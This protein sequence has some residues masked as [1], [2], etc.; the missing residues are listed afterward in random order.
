MWV[1]SLISLFTD[2]ASEMLYPV[3]PL[4][5]KQIGYTAI[6][7][8]V[9]EGVCEAVAG[10]SKGYFGQQSDLKGLRLPFVRA[11][12]TLS[13]ISKPLLVF[14]VYPLWIFIC[15]TMDRLGKGLRTGAR[16]ALLRDESNQATRATVFGFHRS[17]DTAGAAIGPAVALV[18]LYFYPEHYR[19]LFIIASGPGLLAIISTFLIKEKRK[20]PQPVVKSGL[21]S[22]LSYWKTSTSDYRKI[23]IG[24]LL[25][26]LFNSSDVFL[27]LKLK[28][29]GL[30]DSYVI[31]VYIL[32]NLV[33]ALMAYPVGIIA[34][35]LGIR[36][37]FIAGLIL[38]FIVYA[39]FA[40]NNNLWIFLFLMVLY[41]IYAAATEGISKAWISNSVL[42]KDTATA[43]GGFSGFQSIASLFA[44]SFAGLIWYNCGAKYTFLITAGV[45]VFVVIYFLVIRVKAKID[46]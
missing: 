10:L 39:G 26:A 21:F 45:T 3:M 17:M 46:E 36:K 35:K 19:T 18:Y 12:Y 42:K 33:Y 43:I 22:F 16:D 13:A 6:F 8:G 4:Y 40:L 30:R 41:G 27:L 24:L 15:R 34:D 44:S 29:S 2:I 32:Y 28:E 11:G 9:L 20:A 23:C 25:F 14:F 5:L 7:I 31:G 37:I 1:L 38:F